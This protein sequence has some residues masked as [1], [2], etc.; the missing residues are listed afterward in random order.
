MHVPHQLVF[1]RNKSCYDQQRKMNAGGL[2]SNVTTTFVS[3]CPNLLRKI[4]N[5]VHCYK[6]ISW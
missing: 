6:K 5:Q 1:I 2:H 4:K 3:K